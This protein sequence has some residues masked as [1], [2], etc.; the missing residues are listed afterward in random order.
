MIIKSKATAQSIVRAA[1]T[2]RYGDSAGV[3]LKIAKHIMDPY[4]YGVWRS[5]LGR[6]GYAFTRDRLA[7]GKRWS[8]SDARLRKHFM[9][10]GKEDLL[11]YNAGIP[12]VQD[13]LFAV[14]MLDIDAKHGEQ[15]GPLLLEAIQTAL[16]C[17]KIYAE[18][19]TGGKG[20]HGYCPITFTPGMDAEAIRANFLALQSFIK[21]QPFAAFNARFDR[22]NGS[23]PIKD[24]SGHYL[25]MGT[26]AK[27]PRLTTV[28]D[29]KNFIATCSSPCEWEELQ[30]LL[31]KAEHECSPHSS[32]AP[33]CAPVPVQRGKE[34]AH[35]QS[36]GSSCSPTAHLGEHDQQ[37][38]FERARKFAFDYCRRE[39]RP[40]DAQELIGAYERA[41]LA[42]GHRTEDRTRRFEAIAAYIARNFIPKASDVHPLHYVG[43]VAA[44]I[45]QEAADC[46]YGKQRN[47]SRLLLADVALVFW[48]M[49]K[50]RNKADTIELPRDAAIR[51]SRKL[52]ADGQVERVLDH[53]RFAAAKRLLCQVGLLIQVRPG[54]KNAGCAAFRL[55]CVEGS[56]SDAVVVDPTSEG[57]TDAVSQPTTDGAMETDQADTK[58]AVTEAA[59]G[60][61]ATCGA[62]GGV[63]APTSGTS[64]AAGSGDGGAKLPPPLAH[65]ADPS[66]TAS[67]QRWNVESAGVKPMDE[68]LGVR[69]Q[70]LALTQRADDSLQKQ[71]DCE[72]KPK[73]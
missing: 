15:D 28:E 33:F 29:A 23:P 12:L 26:L 60:E 10:D 13:R 5:D 30:E 64:A 4:S 39:N 35:S 43:V 40:V 54:R 69:V 53:K 32:Y 1:F 8:V 17:C 2:S 31:G 18:A 65:T 42:T 25:R 71:V 73:M 63:C 56:G 6:V 66:A 37:D 48:M 49:M 11:W 62:A 58:A 46:E 19:S 45:S 14:A 61:K 3:I 7:T 34:E 59:G 67:F 21:N 68:A 44:R 41:G 55:G 36:V 70:N 22:V 50:N 52:V 51:F 16:P 27:L 57:A 47:R 72:K 38:A 9:G 24:A 20:I